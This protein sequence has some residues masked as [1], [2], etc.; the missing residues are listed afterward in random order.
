MVW[1]A[2]EQVAGFL[3]APLCPCG[4]AWKMLPA[5]GQESLPVD[6]VERVGK[7]NFDKSG[8]VVPFVA[9]A[10]LLGDPETHL[11]A[12]GL[13]DADLQRE[14]KTRQR[15]PCTRTQTSGGE[16]TPSF[17]NGDRSDAGVFFR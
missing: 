12:Q 13:S 15:F 8:C 6:S 16:A 7:V 4:Q 5:L 10:P 3:V 17:P 9:F 1:K 2:N 14:E 11:C